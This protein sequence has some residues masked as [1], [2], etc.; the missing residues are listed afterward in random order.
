MG[1]HEHRPSILEDHRFAIFS[2]GVGCFDGEPIPAT[3]SA[4]VATGGS[5]AVFLATGRHWM[6][7]EHAAGSD[8][9]VAIV[10]ER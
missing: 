2:C 7:V 5:A 3:P 8:A 6:Q 1:L 9:P 4:S 10:I